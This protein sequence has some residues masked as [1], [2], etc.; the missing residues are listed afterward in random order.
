MASNEKQPTIQD[1]MSALLSL[2]ESMDGMNARI[3]VQEEATSVMQDLISEIQPRVSI[4]YDKEE[5]DF[6]DR[7]DGNK[8]DARSSR[9]ETDYKERSDN[10]KSMFQRNVDE[11][12]T[13]AERHAVI[14][15]RQTPSHAHV[16]L[17]STDLSEYAQFVNKWFDWEIQHGIKLEPALIVSKNVRNQL[18]YN[19]N[20]SDT[21][22]NSLTPSAFCSLMAKETRV[23][24]KVHFSETFK[25]AMR[26]TKVLLWDN[27]RP[28]THEK[29]FQG[30]LRRQKIFLRTFQILMEANKEHCPNLEGKE[31]GLAQVFLDLIDKNY[32]KYILAEIPK[33]KDANYSK[34]DKFVDAYVAQAKIHFEAGRAIR[35]VPYGGN[36]FRVTVQTDRR[37]DYN[38]RRDKRFD[39]K[40]NPGR[41]DYARGDRRDSDN[42]RRL[43]F[44][45]VTQ[46]QDDSEEED[47]P[48]SKRDTDGD[49][50]DLPDDDD[51]NSGSRKQNS[52]CEDISNEVASN[53]EHELN[54]VPGSGDYV[55]GCINYALY[56]NCFQGDNCKNVQGH[57]EKIAKETRQWMVRKL[58]TPTVSNSVSPANA[59]SSQ[60]RLPSKIV[61]RDRTRPADRNFE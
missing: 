44:V 41:Q 47:N 20:K 8:K 56:G 25:H 42:V 16:F 6:P 53:F 14:V 22:F 30:I 31:F 34:L 27:V 37:V 3:M 4:L 15:Q 39:S 18:M 10:R 23:F 43:N 33:I 26:D 52:N 38:D 24:S 11:T 1:V 17:S 9:R 54:A 7:D 61:Q 60:Q 49:L 21:D 57:S 13:L 35:L 50:E 58:T 59:S 40:N 19:N 45:D 32:N 46:E 36:D 48:G 12:A 2:K 5:E 29:F 55:K 28:N 51:L